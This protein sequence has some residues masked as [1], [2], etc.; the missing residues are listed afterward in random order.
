MFSSV[1]LEFNLTKSWVQ[2][3]TNVSV[4]TEMHKFT[5]MSLCQVYDQN[6]FKKN[7]QN[8]L[9]SLPSLCATRYVTD[10][11]LSHWKHLQFQVFIAA[12]IDCNSR[13]SEKHLSGGECQQQLYE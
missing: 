9:L 5:G 1:F 6:V 7:L 3:A 13:A 8:R 2:T 10:T 11:Y 12:E 4:E